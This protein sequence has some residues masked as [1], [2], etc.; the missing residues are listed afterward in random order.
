MATQATPAPAQSYVDRRLGS[1]G[2]TAAQPSSTARSW[3]AARTWTIVAA[4]TC[5]GLV[6]RLLLVRGI[7]VDEAISIHQAHM[8]LGGM[9]QNLRATDNHPPLYFLILW[10]TVRLIGSSELAVHVPSIVAGTLLI[11]AVYIA[12]RELFDRRTGAVAALLTTVAPL[13]VWY[14]QEA[15]P[16]AF[17]MLFATLALWA[18]VKALRDGRIRYWVAYGALTIALL[19]T[20]YFSLIPIAIQQ[21]AFAAAIWNRSRHGESVSATITRYW[22]TWIAIAVAVAPLVGYVHQQFAN[23]LTTGQGIASAPSAGAASTGVPQIGHPNVYALITNFAWAIWGYHADSTMLRIAA[24]WPVLMLLALALLGRGRS[25]M[26]LLVLALAVVP[27]LVLMGVG[28]KDRT[29]FEVRYFSGAVPMLMLVC[30]RTVVTSSARRL[31]VALIAVA[32][33]ATMA[34][35]TADQQLAKSNPRDYDFRAALEIVRSRARP[36][37]T[38]L[39]APIYLNDV[40]EYYTP[41]IHAEAVGANN[42]KLPTHGK[43]FLLASFLDQPGIA[44]EVGAARYELKHS[45][46]RLVHTDHLE[47]IYLW[48]YR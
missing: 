14:S 5:V 16:Y 11:P 17:F 41:K 28:F 10:V 12:G 45:R 35:G 22:V 46:M 48:E 31:P 30:A 6:L 4:L 47:K 20:H 3:S 44:G 21:V 40:T 38:L 18:Q 39:Y 42:P 29:L 25:P 43:V 15:R 24:L 9:L 34:A 8:S 13:L 19:Y 23:D 32:L 27:A 36:G 26:S 7:W 1:Q 2:A 33:V 37:D